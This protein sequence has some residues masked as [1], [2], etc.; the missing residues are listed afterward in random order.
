MGATFPQTRF[1]FVRTSIR[2]VGSRQK[3][4]LRKSGIGGGDK[5]LI[6]VKDAYG[7]QAKENCIETEGFGL[8]KASYLQ[9]IRGNWAFALVKT[10][11]AR[12][13]RK[14]RAISGAKGKRSP[15]LVPQT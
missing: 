4:F 5:N 6:L 8:E 2:Y 13:R 11:T 15:L 1:P 3:S 9:R 12:I 10:D 14:G 7:T